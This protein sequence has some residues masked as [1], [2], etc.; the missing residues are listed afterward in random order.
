MV[1]RVTSTAIGA[2]GGTA[3]GL[4]LQA[5]KWNPLD[6]LALAAV[7]GA[8]G[9]APRGALFGALTGGVVGTVLWQTVPSFDMPNAVGIG[10]GSM[11]VG[12]LAQ[13]IARAADA[14]SASEATLSVSLPLGAPR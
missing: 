6:V 5:V 13:W 10:L 3:A 4:A 14:Q 2:A 1:P 11:A 7:G 12:A 9:T 8:I